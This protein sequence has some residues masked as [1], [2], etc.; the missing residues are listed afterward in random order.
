MH[1]S[2]VDDGDRVG[3]LKLIKIKDHIIYLLISVHDHFLIK[4]QT[5][6]MNQTECIVRIK[7]RQT[8]L[9]ITVRSAV[10]TRYYD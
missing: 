5:N 3:T 1:T 8:D 4:L 7:Q 2:V 10:I 9:R 6:S